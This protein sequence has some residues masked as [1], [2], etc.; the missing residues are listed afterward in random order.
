MSKRNSISEFEMIEIRKALVAKDKR[1]K[2]NKVRNSRAEV[3]AARRE[4]N[5]KR[6]AKMKERLALAAKYNITLK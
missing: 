4:Y 2:Y 5:K 1:A 6:Y 3:K